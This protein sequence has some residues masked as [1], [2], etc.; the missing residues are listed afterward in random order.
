MKNRIIYTLFLVFFS[1]LISAQERQEIISEMIE[2]VTYLASDKLEG[3]ATGTVSEQL[4]ANYIVSKFQKYSLLPK[5]DDGFFQ[6]F[7]AKIKENPHSQKIKQ[8]ITGINVVGYVDNNADEAIIIGAH[9]DHIGYG[10]FGS[11][12]DGDNE[13]HNGADDNASGV[14]I[15]INLAKSLSQITDYNYL[16]IAFSGEEHG[17]FGSSY[18]AKNPTIDLKK[19]RFMINFDMVGRLNK[20]RLLAINGVG[21]SMEWV[22]L[23]NKSNKYDLKFKMTESGIGPSDHTS[24]YLQN[25]PSIHFFTGQHED[26][27]KPSDDV[28]KINFD[29]MY[30]IY[31]YVKDIINNSLQIKEFSFQE[32][33]SD[34]TIAPRFKVTLGVMPDYLFDGKGMRIDGVSKGK[35]AFTYGILKGDIVLK[36]GEIDVHDMMTYMHALSQFNHGDTTIVKLNRNSKIIETEVVFQ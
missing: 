17:L 3:R 24:F 27:H 12:H 10:N 29:G 11:R 35:T 13:I 23:I 21:T 19:V 36:M 2:E 1:S 18:Y 28:E 22:D 14:S 15:M 4:A 16:F 30:I 25:I 8:E 33:K 6:Y 26:Y 9:Y 5:G 20:E 34:T 31:N 32:T 7:N